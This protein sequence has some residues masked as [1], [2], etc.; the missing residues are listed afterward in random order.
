MLEAFDS[1]A[2]V[3]FVDV[4][5]PEQVIGFD[6]GG[7]ALQLLLHLSLGLIEKVMLAQFLRL[8]KIWR[9]FRRLSRR[10]AD[11]MRRLL[12]L[13]YWIAE[14]KYREAAEQA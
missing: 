6:A 10:G 3:L 14:K 5:K 11:R 12:S 1:V 2:V 8:L 7:I 4:D 13:E 9:R